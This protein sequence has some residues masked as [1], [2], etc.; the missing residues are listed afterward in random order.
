MMVREVFKGDVQPQTELVFGVMGG[1]VVFDDGSSA[2]VEMT[3][4]VRPNTGERVVIF[5]DPFPDDAPWSRSICLTWR[6]LRSA[7]A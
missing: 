5:A 7:F 3:G 6:R 1:Q 2:Q 4:F